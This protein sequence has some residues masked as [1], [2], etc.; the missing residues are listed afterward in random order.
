MIEQA[1]D[2]GTGFFGL[3]KDEPGNIPNLLLSLPFLNDK[4]LKLARDSNYPLSEK[5]ILEER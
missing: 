5:I 4:E 2:L 1:L 3:V